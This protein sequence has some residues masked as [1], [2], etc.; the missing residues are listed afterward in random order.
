MASYI[1]V[2]NFTKF[3]HYK[4]RRPPWIKLYNDLLEDYSFGCL[5]D[6]SKWLA[7]GLWLLASRSDNRIPNDPLWIARMVHATTPVDLAVLASTGFI[8]ILD[9]DSET[10]APRK[11]VDRLEEEEEEEE[12]KKK[13]DPVR[14]VRLPSD[15]VPNERHAQIAE[16][17]R[18]NLPDEVEKFR[19]WAAS[20]GETKKDWDAAFRNW[21]RNAK[22]SLSVIRGGQTA[23]AD[24]WD[25]SWVD[26]IAPPQQRPA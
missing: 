16:G 24:E 12:E 4:D 25:G 22:P 9:D 6:A 2:K 15:W 1:E 23:S 20:K 17:R 19:D 5:P 8:S 7:V 21:L 10:L 18:V 13:K 3:Q 14:G 26:E 11:Q